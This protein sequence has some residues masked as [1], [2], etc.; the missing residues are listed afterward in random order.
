[1]DNYILGLDLGVQSIGWGIIQVDDDG[2]P[3]AVKQ[4]GVRCFDSGTGSE[5][6]IEQGKDESRNLKRRAARLIRRNQWR[7]KRRTLKLFNILRNNN[8]LPMGHGIGDTPQQRQE[9]INALDKQLTNDFSL[10]NDRINAHLLP[11]K[12]RAFALEQELPPFALGRAFLHLSQ[13]R[14]F[15][16]N[17][18]SPKKNDE[19]EGQIKKDISQL[20][21]D[22]NEKGFRTLG[23]YFASLDPEE[24]RI[25]QRW[26]GRQMFIDEFNAIWNKQAETNSKLTDKLRTKIYDALFFQR[27]LKSQKNLIGKCELE[28]ELRRALAASVEAQQFRYW[29][30]ILDLKVQE[31]NGFFRDL[32][33]NEQDVLANALDHTEKLTF[34]EMR[35]LLDLTK[36]RGAYKFNLETE[37][38]KDIRGNS[39]S[40][41][42]GEILKEKWYTTAETEIDPN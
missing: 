9:L 20:Q 35:K 11:Y 22:I 3:V 21:K 14:G 4:L 24:K 28:P 19:D 16:S 1:M 39:T 40:A 13:R 2:Q 18:K 41:R 17:K 30:K 34:A 36:P 10:L 26:T 6:E 7:R 25:R 37:G 42:I 12:L 32:T 31:P 27:P 38:V 33:R 15:L 29:Q 5:S 23:E 8:L